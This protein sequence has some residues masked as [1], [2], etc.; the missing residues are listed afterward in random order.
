MPAFLPPQRG[1]I[2]SRGG[3]GH[4][5]LDEVEMVG[6]TAPVAPWFWQ[7]P[8]IVQARYGSNTYPDPHS[9]CEAG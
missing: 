5:P 2:F 7:G 1:P 8:E 6:Q 9:S 3:N 4:E